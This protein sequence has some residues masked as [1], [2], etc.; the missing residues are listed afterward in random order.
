M[1]RWL[2]VPALALLAGC[3]HNSSVALERGVLAYD[4]SVVSTS[5]RLLLLNIARAHRSLPLHFTAVSSIAATYDFRFNAGVGP[6]ATGEFG[7]LP[8]PTIG[9]SVGETPTMTIVPM[10][11]DEFTERLLRPFDEPKVAM[12][13]GQGYDVD[14]LFR[15]IGDGFCSRG[16]GRDR[17]FHNRPS[18]REGYTT[19]R[20]I[21]AHLS[22]VQDRNLLHTEA[23]RFHLHRTV[24]V[25][26]VDGAQLNELQSEPSFAFDAERQAY[27]Y[28][29]QVTGRVVIS[30]YAPRELSNEDRLALHAEAQRIATNEILV[31]IR[32][33]RPGGELPIHGSMQMRSFMNIL[34]FL[35]RGVAAEPEFHVPPD[36]RTPD[37]R[38]NPVR[39]LAVVEVSDL[40]LGTELS[41]ALGDRTYAL[42]PQ[43]GYPWNRKAF[44]ILYQLFQMT[45]AASRAPTPLISV[46]R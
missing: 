26:S 37:I 19:F 20:R 23:L 31:D 9:G 6:A 3:A 5:S 44:S 46:G 35:G 18:D 40:P 13:L 11:G 38:E 21:V 16:A 36:P 14:A 25:A 32:E 2:L 12:L 4:H 10:Q 17:V 34:E 45:V 33:G 42:Q 7:W 28:D 29:L 43:G 41:V 27:V 30:N 22:S 15:L 24:P 39:T 8:M 1:K